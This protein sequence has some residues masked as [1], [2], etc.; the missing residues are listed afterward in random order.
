MERHLS[1]SAS[2]PKSL[3]SKSA[4][5]CRLICDRI[6]YPSDLGGTNELTKANQLRNKIAHTLNQSEIQ[7]RMDEL[8]AAYL[9][10]L[11]DQQRPHSEKLDDVRIA[12]GAFELCMAYLVGATE[13]V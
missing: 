13:A 2:L 6:H 9:A 11:S 3:V 4:G 8:R 10:A 7:V 12:A 1:P 5:C